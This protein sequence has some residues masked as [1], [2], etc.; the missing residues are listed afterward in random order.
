[1][2]GKEQVCAWGQW[3][4]TAARNGQNQE[5]SGGISQDEIRKQ[6]ASAK[7]YP[8]RPCEEE[9]STDVGHR[10]CCMRHNEDR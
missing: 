9:G 6:S 7:G 5:E 1:M 8:D 4:P 2:E 3:S 10:L